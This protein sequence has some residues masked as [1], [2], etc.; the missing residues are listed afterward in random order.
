MDIYEDIRRDWNHSIIRW[1][2]DEERVL[3]LS[4]V[5][6]K[7]VEV[8]VNLIIGAYPD[9]EVSLKSLLTGN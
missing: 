6:R 1:N 5:W 2:T 8:T 9:K 3:W 7:P 4:D